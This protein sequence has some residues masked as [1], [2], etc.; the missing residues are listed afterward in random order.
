MALVPAILWPAPGIQG[1][2]R[3]LGVTSVERSSFWLEYTF[4]H[5]IVS[6][7]SDSF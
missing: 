4:H 6:E 3:M 1:L 2:A 5:S 7:V